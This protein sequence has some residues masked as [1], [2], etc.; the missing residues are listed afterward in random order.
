[1]GGVKKS[2]SNEGRRRGEGMIRLGCGLEEETSPSHSYTRTHVPPA[3]SPV[4]A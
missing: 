1:M 3:P 2:S 4:L